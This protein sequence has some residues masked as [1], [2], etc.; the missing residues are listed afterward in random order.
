M[1]TAPHGRPR[2]GSRRAAGARVLGARAVR[3]AIAGDPPPERGL[4]VFSDEWLEAR[5]HAAPNAGASV[6][7][8][9]R[10]Q[11]PKK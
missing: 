2:P 9:A 11:W 3:A 10:H 6:A 4:A 1:K 5:R 8:S 7:A